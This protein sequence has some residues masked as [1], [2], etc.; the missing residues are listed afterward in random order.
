MQLHEESYEKYMKRV[1]FTTSNDVTARTKRGK[2]R[3]ERKVGVISLGS[4]S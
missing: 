3:R 1:I 4:N 2:V